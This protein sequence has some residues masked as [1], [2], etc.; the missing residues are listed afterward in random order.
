[1][2]DHVLERIVDGVF[3]FALGLIILDLLKLNPWPLLVST[4]TLVV[5]GSF[6]VGPSCAKAVEGILLI[7]GR[8]YELVL[9]C[10]FFEVVQGNSYWS[11]LFVLTPPFFTD[12]IDHT[13]S[14]KGLFS[15]TL[16]E[17]KYRP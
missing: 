3:Y 9:W 8:R 15:L 17:A 10:C 6:A 16:L 11:Y 5:A 12:F 7:V 1:M 14:E 4:S 13:I 2:I